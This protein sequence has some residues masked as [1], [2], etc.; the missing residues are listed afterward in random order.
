[1]QESLIKV[2]TDKIYGMKLGGAK[3]PNL[4]LGGHGHIPPLEMSLLEGGYVFQNSSSGVGTYSN[5][6]GR[7]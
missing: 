7:Q 6:Y 2:A 4:H 1:M 3:P 5:F